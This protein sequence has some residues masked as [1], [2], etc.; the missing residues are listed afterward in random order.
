[1][2][3]NIK[4]WLLKPFPIIISDSKKIKKSISIGAFIF[5]FLFVFK[6]FGFEGLGDN[7]LHYTLLYSVITTITLLFAFFI[8]PIFFEGFFNASKW[9]IY[10]EIIFELV[11]MLIIGVSNWFF[12]GYS[13]NFNSNSNYGILFFIGTALSVGFLPTLILVFL[14]EK[15]NRISKRS[16]AQTISIIK[17]KPYQ[18]KDIIINIQGYNK[19][20][21]LTI[22]T[23]QLLYIC[24]EKNY[25]SVFYLEH[26]QVKEKLIR[27]TLNKI[28]EQLKG[29]NSII[30]CH[31]SYIIN[32]NHVEKITGNAR[33]YILK[34][35][36]ID[37]LVPVSRK[38][39]KEL[40]FTLIKK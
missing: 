4:N 14:S 32:S 18:P 3:E 2:I 38:F 40:L 39:P 16:I 12:S 1:M 30:R 21:S 7:I 6:P 9:S 35:H 25:A 24:C 33:N 20:E 8:L 37:V 34:M 5:F 13:T 10:K 27:T 15:K 19:N 28:E 23:E 31:K 29:N 22:I 17:D 36:Q 26:G 11:I